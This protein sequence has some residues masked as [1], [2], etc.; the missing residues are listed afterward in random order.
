MKT[1]KVLIGLAGFLLAMAFVF[2]SCDRD[3]AVTGVELNRTELVTLA[4]GASDTLIATVSPHNATNQ[5]VFWTTDCNGEVV[6]VREGIVTAMSVGTARVTV[7]TQEGN[8]AAYVYFQVVLRTVPV[9]SV[10]IDNVTTAD[11]EEIEIEIVDGIKTIAVSHGNNFFSFHYTL[12]PPDTEEESVANRRVIWTSRDAAV[13]VINSV[14]MVTNISP[15]TTYVV[16]TSEEDN[17]VQ[18]SVRVTIEP[19]LLERIYIR[20]NEVNVERDTIIIGNTTTYQIHFEPSDA[21]FQA[22]N[23]SVTALDGSPI[24]PATEDTIVTVAGG[25]VRGIIPGEVY[26]VATSVQEGVE[27]V[28]VRITVVGIPVTGVSLNTGTLQ[29]RAGAMDT[30][31]RT[32]YPADATN[33]AVIWE[34]S[35]PTVAQVRILEAVWWEFPPRVAVD[36]LSEGT[37]TITVRTVDG[38]FEA[39][40]TVTV[41]AGVPPECDPNGV[42]LVLGS[43]NPRTTT[44][45]TTGNLVWSDVVVATGC[46]KIDYYAAN[47]AQP[48]PTTFQSDCR[49]GTLTGTDVSFFSW[50]AVHRFSDV[51]CPAP[52]RVPTRDDFD[53]LDR[54]FGGNGT[55]QRVNA[56]DLIDSLMTYWGAERLGHIGLGGPVPDEGAILS[57]SI[58]HRWFPV[59]TNGNFATHYWKF[60]EGSAINGRTFS[61]NHAQTSP[62]ALVRTVNPNITNFSKHSAAIL[63]CVRDN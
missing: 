31:E 17:S 25:A 21:S 41:T 52:W 36:G 8:W 30:L 10:T 27:P 7:A 53:A 6:A 11:G 34:T 47:L 39:T 28:R 40:A 14:G 22:I 43:V 61:F 37:A 46:N 16:V 38:D 3:T 18:D 33:R 50:C 12:G 4:V 23:W 20:L 32:V 59:G 58:A 55:A 26:V 56:P 49:R 1:K 51:L 5:N 9:E 2:S 62:T 29:I 42:T 24:G 54:Y 60:G 15:G 13:V 35:D 63:R 44:T 19:I 57:P 48:L 45:W